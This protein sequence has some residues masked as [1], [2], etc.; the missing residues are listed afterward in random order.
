VKGDGPTLGLLVVGA[1][2]NSPVE[3]WGA[4]SEGARHNVR[5][6]TE[7]VQG[8]RGS[9]S[10]EDVRRLIGEGRVWRERFAFNARICVGAGIVLFVRVI[11]GVGVV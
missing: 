3:R 1:G 9:A 4:V 5:V 10:R 7:V 6:G 11:F 2:P 8:Q